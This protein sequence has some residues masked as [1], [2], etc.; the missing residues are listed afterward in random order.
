MTIIEDGKGTGRKAEVN[1]ENQLVV[2]AINETELEHASGKLGTG[3]SWDS[4]ELD[5]AANGTMLFVKNTGT[6]PLI[7][8]KAFIN[9]DDTAPILWTVLTGNATTTPSGTV[10]NEVNLN[11]TFS[12][13]NAEADAFAN[14]T[15]VADGDII[16]RAKTLTDDMVILDLTGIVLGK[17]HYVQINQITESDTGSAVLFGHFENPS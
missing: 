16:I 7:L 10:V 17:G 2:R 12:T 11:K 6:T 15:A 1:E 14:E 13:K 5:I 9:G 4:T 3:F 8:D